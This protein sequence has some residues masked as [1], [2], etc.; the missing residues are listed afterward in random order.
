MDKTFSKTNILFHFIKKETKHYYPCK[1]F[2]MLIDCHAIKQDIML[3][4]QAKAAPHA[5]D[6]LTDVVAVDD[7]C[8]TAWRHES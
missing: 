4:A 6:V 3:R 5:R 2:Q 1:K 7:G 8:P